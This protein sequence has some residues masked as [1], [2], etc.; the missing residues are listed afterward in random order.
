MAALPEYYFFINNMIKNFKIT[1]SA[2]SS[3]YLFNFRRSTIKYLVKKKFEIYCLIPDQDYSYQLK[4]LGCNCIHI[5]IQRSGMNPII[6][7]YTSFKFYKAY[8]LINPAAAFHFTVKNNIFGTFGAWFAGIPSVNN[9]SGLGT[10]FIK[11]SFV[12]TLVKFL[13]KLSQPLAYKVFCQNFDDY[14]LLQSNG[15]V[16]KDKLNVLPGSGVDIERFSPKKLNNTQND[17]LI[18]LYAGRFLGDKGLNELIMAANNIHIKNPKFKLWLSGALDL[19]NNSS[20]SKNTIEE[21]KK[22]D[23]IS[24]MEMTDQ[25]EKVL[26]KVNCVVL[27]SYREG[28]PKI[29]LEAS[30]MGLPIITT[31]VP[32]CRE[33]IN[34]NV[35]G[36][37]CQ[38]KNVSSLQI[39]MEK[40]ISLDRVQ[41][42]AL[43]RNGRNIIEKHFDEKVVIKS[44][45]DVIKEI[46]HYQFEK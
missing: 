41:L 4:M 40:V 3:W 2:N 14:A 38:P 25:I 36:F 12:S 35:N 23:F 1:L 11:K 6:D 13:Y 32:G 45:H 33:I 22:I 8:K 18:F 31:D 17:S 44:A 39:A 34:N 16:P 30:A 21:W 27:P 28:M 46:I 20:I 37:I 43:G 19:E 15:L 24:I 10:V 26:S 29:L 7:L 42:Q 9:F 5:P